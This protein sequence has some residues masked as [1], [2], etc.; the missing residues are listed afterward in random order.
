MESEAF[1]KAPAMRAFLLY[2]TEQ[3]ALGHADRLKEQ[4]IGVEVLGR[5]PGYDPAQDNIVRVRANEL[6]GRLARYFASEG[7]QE[8]LV[9]TI[10]KGGYAPEVV[11]REFYRLA[12]PRKLCPF[13]KLSPKLQ[14]VRDCG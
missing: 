12:P 5:R 10:P 8:P 13:R 7:A 11:Y 1:C 6:R 4:T 9:I 2:I 3:A 14:R